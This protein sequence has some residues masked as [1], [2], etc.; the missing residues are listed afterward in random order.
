MIRFALRGVVFLVGLTPLFGFASQD[1]MNPLR[2]DESIP[3]AC[4]DLDVGNFDPDE[5][6]YITFGIQ[7]AE[8]RGFDYEYPIARDDAK[9]L[10][11]AIQRHRD[12]HRNPP[13]FKDRNLLKDFEILV[14]HYET[15]DF[16]F[17]SE[18]EV[19]ELLAIVSLKSTLPTDYFVTGSVA[20]RDKAAGEL[21]LVIGQSSNCRV[22]VVG[23]AK[24]GL[25]KLGYARRQLERFRNFIRSHSP[26][27]GFEPLQMPFSSH[28]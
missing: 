27:T 26:L 5:L 3:E 13:H 20:Y 11:R 12:G 4:R 28:Y 15:M 19:L 8:A 1:Y 24:L 23:E 6:E 16:D 10:W 7:G 17:H 25:K 18:G 21:D 22:E 14:A 9:D 2:W